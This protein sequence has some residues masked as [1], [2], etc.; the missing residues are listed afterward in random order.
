[1]PH[2]EYQALVMLSVVYASLR[3]V[4]EQEALNTRKVHNLRN[5]MLQCSQLMN[6]DAPSES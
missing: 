2:F 4:E 5:T 3:K 6:L 1:M